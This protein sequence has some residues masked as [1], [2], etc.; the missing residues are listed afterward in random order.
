MSS[1]RGLW[2]GAKWISRMRLEPLNYFCSNRSTTGECSIPTRHALT[3][4]INSNC[5]PIQFLRNVVRVIGLF[6]RQAHRVTPRNATRIG[7]NKSLC[8][9]HRVAFRVVATSAGRTVTTHTLRFGVFIVGGRRLDIMRIR[10]CRSG[11]PAT[12]DDEHE[13]KQIFHALTV[14]KHRSRVNV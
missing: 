8:T 12:S 4:R 10:C 3:I 7:A 1:P 13:A 2:W 9:I 5:R 6:C 14:P 11:V